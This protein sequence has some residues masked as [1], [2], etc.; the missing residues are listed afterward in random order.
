MD[1]QGIIDSLFKAGAHFGYSRSRRHPSTLKYLFGVKGGVEI[2]DLEKTAE[3]LDRAMVF[4]RGLAAD[5]KTLLFV[6]SKA[7]SRESVKATAEALNLPYV[8]GRFIGG[9]ITNF[10][11]IKKRIDRLT[12][13]TSLREKGELAKFTK[14]ERLLIDREIDELDAMF[15]GLRGMTKIPHAML[16][17][18]PKREKIAIEE[19]RKAKI[20][21]VALLNSDCDASLITYPV[22]GN[23]ATVGS[24]KFFLEQVK[25][26]WEEGAKDAPALRDPSAGE[27]GETPAAPAEAT[28]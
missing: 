18:D 10:N 26:A 6:S 12:E 27:A 21:T 1:T 7:E 24:V 25:A 17:V 9:T 13:L 28:A 3:Q 22:P 19:A 11:E 23:D 5:R 14:L 20:P 8:A 16:V 15:G 4:I 2:F